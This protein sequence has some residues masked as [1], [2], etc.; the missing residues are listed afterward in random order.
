MIAPRAL[1]GPFGGSSDM[2][3]LLASILLVI[4]YLTLQ[5]CQTM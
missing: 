5:R 1:V 4:S 2:E 3:T